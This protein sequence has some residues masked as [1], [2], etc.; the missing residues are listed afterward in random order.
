M[1]RLFSGAPLPVRPT[2]PFRD[3]KQEFDLQMVPYTE[4]GEGQL[5]GTGLCCLRSTDDNYIA[6][7]GRERY[8]RKY[9]QGAGV[10]VGDS[11]TGHGRPPARAAFCSGPLL[12]KGVLRALGRASGATLL[13]AA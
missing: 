9:K 8:E 4:L 2:L 11:P 7:W 1:Q 10:E 12:S 13:T 5:K 6:L 3:T